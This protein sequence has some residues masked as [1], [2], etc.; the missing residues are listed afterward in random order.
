MLGYVIGDSNMIV[1]FRLVGVEGS[2]V[3]SV[4]EASQALNKALERND[5]AII[6]INEEFST[7]TQLQETINQVRRERRNPLIVELPGSNG[8]PRETR[9]PDL[10]SK[11][12]G[13]SV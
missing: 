4:D 11:I 12:L 13:V 10:I 8:K 6:I 9:L 7:Q 2:E 1:G 3:K 5:L